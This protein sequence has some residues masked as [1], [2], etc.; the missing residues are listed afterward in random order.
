VGRGVSEGTTVDVFVGKNIGVMVAAG[1]G[2]GSGLDGWVA[3]PDVAGN[4]ETRVNPPHPRRKKVN[5]TIQ[6]KRFR[7]C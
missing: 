4:G 2:E 5:P 3:T 7:K 6:I 1:V